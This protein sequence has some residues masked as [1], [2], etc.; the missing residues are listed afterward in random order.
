MH[1]IAQVVL[2]LW[3]RHHHHQLICIYRHR[4][5][6]INTI[7]IVV[8]LCSS[9]PFVQVV[10]GWSWSPPVESHPVLLVICSTLALH[11][12]HLHRHH[13]H[14]LLQFIIIFPI[15]ILII[16]TTTTSFVLRSW[17]RSV[18]L[19]CVVRSYS[20]SVM[21]FNCVLRSVSYYWLLECVP[22]LCYTFCRV[23][24]LCLEKLAKKCAPPLC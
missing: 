17:L 10:L 5:D 7:Y 6:F 20:P 22:P 8:Y 18:S 19:L 11:R 15:T 24:Q 13:H 4:N 14:Q 12:H 2:G 3:G 9:A 16:T 23:L 21:V 1:P